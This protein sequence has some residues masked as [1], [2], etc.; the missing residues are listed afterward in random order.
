M[1]VKKFLMQEAREKG[2]CIDGFREMRN[3]DRSGLLGYYLRTIDWSLERDYP[4]LA[5]ARQFFPDSEEYGIYLDRTFDGDVFCGRQIYV[6]HNCKGHINVAMDYDN[7]I[8]PM[9]YFANGC[10]IAVG[11]EQQNIS[12]I[13]VPLYV[14][15][16]NNVTVTESRNAIF[17][18]FNS[19]I[20]SA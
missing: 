12:P 2:I 19:P 13:R 8:I 6:F 4:S 9:L 7:A 16:N 20:I 18:K 10:N 3:Y 14:F 5:F 11:C 17:T 1:D 15:G